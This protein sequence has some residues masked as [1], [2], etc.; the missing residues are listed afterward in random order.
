MER[1][2]RRKHQLYKLSVGE[3]QLKCEALNIP[4][5]GPTCVLVKTIAKAEGESPTQRLQS[6]LQ[7]QP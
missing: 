6:E 1:E 2:T 4:L 3:L 5:K 7:R